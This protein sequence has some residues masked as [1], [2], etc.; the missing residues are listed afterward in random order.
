MTGIEYVCKLQLKKKRDYGKVMDVLIKNE[1]FTSWKLG[2]FCSPNSYRNVTQNT[3]R[4]HILFLRDIQNDS[5]M[6][7]YTISD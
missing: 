1:H 5:T 6:N 7:S 2:N 3:K 4:G